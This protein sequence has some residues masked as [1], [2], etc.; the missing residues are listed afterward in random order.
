MLQLAKHVLPKFQLS[1]SYLDGLRQL[2]DH[3]SSKLQIISKKIS[4]FSISEKKS[5]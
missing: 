5:K 2:F 1:S 4:K 3:F